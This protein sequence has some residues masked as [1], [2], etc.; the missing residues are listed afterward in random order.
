MHI[1]FT[2]RAKQQR[3]HGGEMCFQSGK[4]DPE[5]GKDDVVT[6]LYEPQEELVLSAN[7]LRTLC[8]LESISASQ[9]SA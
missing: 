9:A 3:T 2:L 7:A 1:L 6:A 4:Q 8:R 5:D